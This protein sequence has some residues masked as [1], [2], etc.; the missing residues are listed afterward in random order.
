[1]GQI[2]DMFMTNLAMPHSTTLVWS[3]TPPNRHFD[4]DGLTDLGHDVELSTV[5]GGHGVAWCTVA[6]CTVA[7][8]MYSPSGFTPRKHVLEKRSDSGLCD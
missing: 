5:Y 1:M 3:D 8:K 2:N 4:V 6:W 7:L